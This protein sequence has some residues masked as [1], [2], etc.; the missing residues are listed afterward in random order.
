MASILNA[1]DTSRPKA[2]LIAC[3]GK[4]PPGNDGKRIIM[5]AV[6]IAARK[7]SPRII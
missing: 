6:K 7:H 3:V 1:D 2:C 4:S 5:A